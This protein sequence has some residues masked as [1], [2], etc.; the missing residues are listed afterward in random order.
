MAKNTEEEVAEIDGNEGSESSNKLFAAPSLD[1]STSSEASQLKPLEAYRTRWLYFT[2]FAFYACSGRFM[3]LYYS[4][5]GLDESQIGV[6]FAVPY[7]TAPVFSALVGLF[8]D[9]L[10]SIAPMLWLID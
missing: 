1:E 5:E 3:S 8:A 9:G 7:V 4:D 10:T 2:L 6:V